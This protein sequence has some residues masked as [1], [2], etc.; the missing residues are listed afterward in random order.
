MEHNRP[1]P[2]IST[3]TSFGFRMSFRSS[4]VEPNDYLIMPIG[5]DPI[6]PFRWSR[7]PGLFLALHGLKKFKKVMLSSKEG[8]H[9]AI[10]PGSTFYDPTP[11]GYNV[12]TADAEYHILIRH[13]ISLGDWSGNWVDSEIVLA[14]KGSGLA[15]AVLK[16]PDGTVTF[17]DGASFTVKNPSF[18]GFMPGH[19]EFFDL[20]GRRQFR[21]DRRRLIWPESD[22]NKRYLLCLMILDRFM[23]DISLQ[24]G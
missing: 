8:V 11:T 23:E 7:R 4:V 6:G 1:L 18:E 15:I 3:H 2:F 13:V 20:S 19:Y 5:N 16:C 24:Y 21:T 10:E 9:A 22:S 14:E 17:R 12:R